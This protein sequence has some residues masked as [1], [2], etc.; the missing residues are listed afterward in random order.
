MNPFEPQWLVQ[1]RKVINIKKQI[2]SLLKADA[3]A[4]SIRFYH[5]TA[6]SFPTKHIPIGLHSK[7]HCVLCE[8]KTEIVTYNVD[9]FC[10]RK[11]NKTK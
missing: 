9:D 10:I 3:R 1:H 7:E 5:E 2:C 11:F 4:Y 8:V 6:I